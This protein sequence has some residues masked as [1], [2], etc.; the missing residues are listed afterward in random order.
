[1]VSLDKL[2]LNK[3]SNTFL[4]ND[5]RGV[6]LNN[7]SY[8][9]SSS[10][11]SRNSAK[12]YFLKM[13]YDAQL[14]MQFSLGPVYTGLVVVPDCILKNHRVIISGTDSSRSARNV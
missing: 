12:V 8:V 2:S 1:M 11:C 14:I 4:A 7:G 6:A 10:P 13:N 3:P 9:V 5:V